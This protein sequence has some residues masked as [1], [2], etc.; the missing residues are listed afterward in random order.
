MPLTAVV[1]NVSAPSVTIAQAS[2]LRELL[3]RDDTENEQRLT[4]GVEL[5]EIA[6]SRLDRPEPQPIGH[7][8]ADDDQITRHGRGHEPQ[9]HE[10][11][12]GEHHEGGGEEQLVRSRIEHAAEGALPTESLGDEP[13]EEVGYGGDEEQA[14]RDEELMVQQS[15]CDRER[16]GGSSEP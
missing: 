7:C 14:E 5:A 12:D 13:V 10:V 8:A 16:S 15:H 4:Q 2:G 6:G 1:R 3:A 9:R 11:H